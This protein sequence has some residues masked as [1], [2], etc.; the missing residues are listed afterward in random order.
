LW[1]HQQIGVSDWADR[2]DWAD[3]RGVLVVVV[4]SSQNVFVVAAHQPDQPDPPNP[5]T[6]EVDASQGL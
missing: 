1:T 6:K 3:D 5:Q 4:R 2:A